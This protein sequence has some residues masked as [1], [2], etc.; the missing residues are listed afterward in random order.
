M[1]FAGRVVWSSNGT[2]TVA[3]RLGSAGFGYFPYGYLG[4]VCS[5]YTPTMN[6]GFA[7][8]HNDCSSGL[9]YAMNRYY[10]PARGRF[11]TPDPSSSSYDL[12]NPLSFNRYAYVTGDPIN[13]NDPNGLDPD[14]DENGDKDRPQEGPTFGAMPIQPIAQKFD[15]NVAL[16][17]QD[18]I[19][20]GDPIQHTLLKVT[21]GNQAA[22]YLEAGPQWVATPVLALPPIAYLNKSSDTSKPMYP[23]PITSVHVWSNLPESICKTINMEYNG[24]GNLKI[25]YNSM[26]PAVW[27]GPNSNSFTHSLLHSVDLNLSWAQDL[28][29]SIFAPGWDE[30][31]IFP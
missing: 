12:K 23:L 18:A 6:P 31:S 7:T 3:D 21:I 11:T 8:Y 16:F 1:Q 9:D 28:R 30:T 19:F 24:Y 13:R 27:A 17:R 5:N 22:E 10:D 15:C 2:E 29:M 25:G 14:E 20:G 26:G 4:G